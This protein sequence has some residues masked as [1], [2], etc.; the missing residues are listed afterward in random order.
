MSLTTFRCLAGLSQRLPVVARLSAV[1]LRCSMACQP[2]CPVVRRSGRRFIASALMDD[3]DKA[4]L[5]V[6]QAPPKPTF[7]VRPI[8]KGA[9][10]VEGGSWVTS[11]HLLKPL[12]STLCCGASPRW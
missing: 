4:Q 5:A 9:L 2:V 3:A 11:S 12:C 8:T 1:P 6:A 7:R 10:R